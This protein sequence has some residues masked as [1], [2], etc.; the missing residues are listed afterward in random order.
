MQQ[1]SEVLTIA[2]R[3]NIFRGPGN[4]NDFP[5]WG[6]TAKSPGYQLP[7]CFLSFFSAVDSSG[8]DFYLFG[9]PRDN[10]QTSTREREKKNKLYEMGIFYLEYIC[11]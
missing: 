5:A 8:A 3:L 6:Y 1:E 9:K 4:I 2:F 10:S 7:P 11:I